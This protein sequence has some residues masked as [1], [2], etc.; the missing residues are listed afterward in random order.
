M[1]IAYDQ[2]FS[3]TV[4]INARPSEVW[5]ALTDQGMMRAWMSD[6][7]IDIT[8]NWKVGSPI[9]IQGDLYK[10][11]FEN[12]GV[13][14]QFEPEQ[15]LQYSHLSSLS[16]LPDELE[17]YSVITFSLTPV[18]DQTTL[19]LTLSNFPTE[20]IYKHLAFYWSVTL[21]LI[22]SFIEPGPTS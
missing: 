9:T 17:N 4:N 1:Q 3:K 20:T 10:K 12:K 7:P 16:R 19:T 11:R 5:K 15:V 14:L 8:T 13:V 22:K 21:E 18:E 6:S 2:I